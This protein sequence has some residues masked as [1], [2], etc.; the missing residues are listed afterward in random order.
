MLQAKNTK[1][2]EI[3]GSKENL[4]AK[5]LNLEKLW[6]YTCKSCIWVVS[7]SHYLKG[8]K[9]RL[10]KLI[11]S[12]GEA[13]TKNKTEYSRWQPVQ[14]SYLLPVDRQWSDFRPLGKRSTGR[15]TVYPK[16]RVKT[17]CRSI[18]KNREHCSC[19][20]STGR[21][22]EVHS[23]TLVHVSRPADRPTEQFSSASGR[24]ASRPAEGQNRIL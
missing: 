24:P 4:F 2:L 5:R 12:L 23:C 22:T 6:F 10:E 1:G 13:P 3:Y 7:H 19:F 17:L 20:R 11:D 16:Q 9:I 18:V 14:Q 21:S 15:S 8:M